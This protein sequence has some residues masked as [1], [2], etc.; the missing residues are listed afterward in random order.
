MAKLLKS[1]NAKSK[2]VSIEEIGRVC[3]QAARGFK[4][5]ASTKEEVKNLVNPLL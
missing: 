3:G 1:Q 4:V 5:T 2:D